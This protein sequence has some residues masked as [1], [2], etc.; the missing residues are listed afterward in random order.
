MKTK[1]IIA[2][3]APYEG[4]CRL[5]GNTPMTLEDFQK[6]P[7]NQRQYMLSMHRVVT[8]IEAQK[9]KQEFNW[10]D[11]FQGKYSAWWD[12]ETYGDAEPGSGFSYLGYVSTVTATDVGARLCSFSPE[13]TRFIA[14]VMFEDY[15]VIMKG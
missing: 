8:V 3:K 6:F 5:L 2:K 9:Q 10:N 15:K 7:E 4:A 13:E 12:M 11:M 14:E 1:L